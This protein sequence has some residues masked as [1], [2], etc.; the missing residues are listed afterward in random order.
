VSAAQNIGDRESKIRDRE[1]V[2]ARTDQEH[3]ALRAQY[4]ELNN[5]LREAW[6]V[7]EELS[8]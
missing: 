5:E 4:T 7:Q 2:Q 3:Q 6:R 1:A 8:K